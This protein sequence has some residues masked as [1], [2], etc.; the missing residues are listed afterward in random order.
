M[1]WWWISCGERLKMSH[2]LLIGYGNPLRRDDGFGS[3]LAQRLQQE[4]SDAN[5]EII[6]AHQLTPRAWLNR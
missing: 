1:E 2:V 3:E 4:F 5:V 6:A